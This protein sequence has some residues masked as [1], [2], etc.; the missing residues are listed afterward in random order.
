MG[1]IIYTKVSLSL[2]IAF[3]AMMISHPIH[4]Q[5]GIGTT[6]P[7][8]SAVLDIQ[9]S[10]NDK[11]V[12]IPRMTQAQR[13]AIS[14]PATGLM[15]FQ[16]D[17]NVGFYF[18]DGSSWESFGEVKTV[19]GNSPAA[20]GN[21]TLTF[22][23]TQTGTQAQR[24]ATAS[25]T[26]GLVHIV[27]GDPTPS[28]NDKVYI[29]ST[30]L[31]SWT[32]SSGFTDTDEQDISGSS[33]T[34]ATS[35]LLIDIE[36]GSGQTLDLS[37]LEELVNDADPATN[38]GGASQGDLAY[39][40]TDD[41]LQVYD[42][43]SWVAVSSSVVTPT[44]DQVTDVGSTTTNSIEVGGATVTGDLTVNTNTTLEGNTTIGDAS[45]DDLTITARLDSDLIPKSDDSRSLGS[46]S[47]NFNTVNTLNV[48][49]NA[50]M[51]VSSTAKLTLNTS[52]TGTPTISLQQGGTEMAGIGSSTF[53]IGDSTSGNH[54]FF[55]SSTETSTFDQVLLYSNLSSNT[56]VWSDFILISPASSDGE[57]L[58]WDNTNSRWVSDDDIII[59][60][61]SYGSN[62]SIDNS[63]IP[64]DPNINL[65]QASDLFFKVF[66]EEINS[67]SSQLTL[68]TTATGT[69]TISFQQGGTE[70]AGIGSSTF[71][72]GDSTSGN[73][74][75]FPQNGGSL[76]DVL[77]FTST[78]TL[79]VYS[80]SN[81]EQDDLDDVLRR[82][83]SS[84]R[85]ANIRSLV[86]SNTI[87][88]KGT[89]LLANGTTDDDINLGNDDGDDL[90]IE[91]LLQSH[92]KF[93]SNNL[94]DIG[95][96][97][98]NARNIYSRT[99]ISNNN[100]SINVSSTT[101]DQIFLSKVAPQKQV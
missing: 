35:A 86:A 80:V 73:H 24:A 33:F 11:G 32:L 43:S 72:I 17:G 100:L 55:P 21:V 20:D 101:N 67:G 89:A 40:T 14:S 81:L 3:L 49:S 7:D 93:D 88:S 99:L 74:Y 38:L 39:D 44:L 36:D 8:A 13:N 85:D 23:A 22:L 15:I 65:G 69:P 9:S 82:D 78:N 53:F 60:D 95:T 28:E 52:A 51:T 79:E 4:A 77:A 31:A 98:S 92:F 75:F 2:L 87:E 41:E 83:P 37:A 34:V 63:I 84:N 70:L 56:L 26:D 45:S 91:A 30:G 76:G 58:K 16:T 68:N 25:P 47:L 57:I 48:T 66:T 29:Y 18:Y 42:G 90:I 19:N 54:Y 5:V 1:Q 59:D 27:T 96:L 6:T 10:S 94:Y 46:S 50:G 97:A 62:I 61:S 71:F 12:L 64:R